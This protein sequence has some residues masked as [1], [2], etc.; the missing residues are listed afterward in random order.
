MKKAI[1]LL[2]MVLTSVFLLTGV[3]SAADKKVVLR[4]AGQSPIE[5]MSTQNMNKLKAMV[6]KE[7]GGTIELKLYPANQLGDYV[8]VYEELMR[9]SLD[10]ALISISPQF[11]PKFQMDGI[12]YLIVDYKN[13]NKYTDRNGAFFKAMSSFTSENNIILLGFHVDGLMGLGTTK[14]IKDPL[15]PTISDQGLLIRIPNKESAKMFLNDLGYKTVSVAY[16]E[17]FTALQTGVADG[18][19]GGTA[20]LNFVGFRDVIKNYYDLKL[21]LEQEYF[22]MSNN[23]WA[24]LSDNQKKIMQDAIMKIEKMSAEACEKEDAEFMQKMRDYGIKV[25]T[26]SEKDLDKVIQHVRSKVWPKY[27]KY[28]GDDNAKEIVDYFSK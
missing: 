2:I 3:V 9:G 17:L 5:H 22:L 4:M 24:K 18:W 21:G 27:G 6:E 7:S 12:P 26:Y 11:N 20:N 13:L 15:N 25:H 23:A 28:I 8:Q 19:W 10:L 1:F 16:A 14:P